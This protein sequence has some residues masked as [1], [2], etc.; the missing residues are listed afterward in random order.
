MFYGKAR[1]IVLECS[2]DNFTV[3]ATDDFL[4][5][6][7]F[8]FGVMSLGPTIIALFSWVVYGVTYF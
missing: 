6:T 5:C 7:Y 3:Y 4:Y 2:F 1:L 8:I